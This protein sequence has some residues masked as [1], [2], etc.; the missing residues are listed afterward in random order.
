[1]GSQQLQE[2]ILMWLPRLIHS[3]FSQKR[4]ANLKCGHV[5]LGVGG[6]WSYGSWS[7]N[8]TDAISATKVLRPNLV[9]TLWD[10]VC[11]GTPISFINKTDR[12]DI[13]DIL[14]KVAWNTINHTPVVLVPNITVEH[15]L[16][17]KNTTSL[18]RFDPWTSHTEISCSTNWDK[19]NLHIQL[20]EMYGY[21]I[22][23]K[24]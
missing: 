5:P 13:T 17:L 2:Q 12:H 8:Y 1:M 16:S 23:D 7:Y 4:N 10:K 22:H 11:P 24:W 15:A 18:M 3:S 6:S 19:R 21:T 20:A 9:S 14:L